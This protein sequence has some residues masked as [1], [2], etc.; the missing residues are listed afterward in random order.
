MLVVG[1]GL[2]APA[3]AQV[4]SN[5]RAFVQDLYRGWCGTDFDQL[6]HQ[7]VGH[8]IE[9]RIERDVIVD[10]DADPRPFAQ[11][12][13]FHRQRLQGHFVDRFPN[14]RP[15]PILL[16]KRPV[17]QLAQQFADGNIQLF[18]G[19]ELA[20]AQRRHDPA[21]CA[22]CTA[23]STLALSLGLYGRAGTIPKPQ[24]SAKL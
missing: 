21:L 3:A 10:V 15:R 24:C 23:F 6:M 19:E 22:T 17:I 18:E 8:A 13:W 9:V 12:E 20:V 7:V 16:T 5:A 2:P 1:D 11:I 4:R 14:R